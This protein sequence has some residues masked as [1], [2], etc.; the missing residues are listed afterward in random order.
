MSNSILYFPKMSVL[1]VLVLCVRSNDFWSF[2]LVSH[3][4]AKMRCPFINLIAMLLLKRIFL[5]YA[6]FPLTLE[7]QCSTDEWVLLPDELRP[8]LLCFTEQAV[9]T[10]CNFYFWDIAEGGRREEWWWNHTREAEHLVRIK[11]CTLLK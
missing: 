2:L 7:K 11:S 3:A 6:V 4:V 10:L 9:R 5:S 8:Q 1:M